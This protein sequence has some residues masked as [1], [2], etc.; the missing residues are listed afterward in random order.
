METYYLQPY[1]ENVK[2]HLLFTINPFN[3]TFKCYKLR[4]EKKI[5]DTSYKR[6][7]EKMASLNWRT[8]YI[9]I[10]IQVYTN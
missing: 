4:E 2:E 1:Y 9:R 5:R 8:Y 6:E 3:D 7:T 10:L